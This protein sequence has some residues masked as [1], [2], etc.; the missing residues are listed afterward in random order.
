MPIMAVAVAAAAAASAAA[1]AALLLFLGG[2][3][4]TSFFLGEE[5]RVAEFVFGGLGVH[6]LPVDGVLVGSE[7]GGSGVGSNF[8]ALEFGGGGN[9]VGVAGCGLGF[10]TSGVGFLLHGFAGAE[11]CVPVARLFANSVGG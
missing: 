1:F 10:R 2:L 3:F 6:T 4:S 8:S 7:G 9:D 5:S 11:A